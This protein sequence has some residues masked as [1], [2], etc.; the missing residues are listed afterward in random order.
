[1]GSIL[2]I[3]GCVFPRMCTGRERRTQATQTT[4]KITP[5]PAGIAVG[6]SH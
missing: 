3:E 1:M 4:Q 6:F 5:F 2:K